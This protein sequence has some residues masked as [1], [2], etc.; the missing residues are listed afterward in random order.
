[1]IR[2]LAPALVLLLTSFQ[3]TAQEAITREHWYEAGTTNFDVHSLL[4]REKTGVMAT[5]L[6][7]WRQIAVSVLGESFSTPVDPIRTH[8]FLF[9]SRG[10]YDLFAEGEDDAYMY[11]SPRASYLILMDDETSVNLAQHHYAHFLINNRPVGSPRWY[12]EGMANYFSRIDVTKEEA[13][14]R[15]LQTT[16]V[17]LA[18]TLNDSLS[19]EEL[20][21]DDAALASPRLIQIANLKSA[22]FVHFLLNG[23]QFEGFT[24]RR[25]QLQNYLGFLQ[26]GRAQRFAY[27]RAF[28]ISL[29]RLEREYERF[30]QMMLD[31]GDP[32]RLLMSFT[33]ELA[34]EASPAVGDTITSELA[35]LSLHAGK[36]ESS[37]LF[38]N[39]LVAK[40][41]QSGRAYSGLADSRRMAFSGEGAEPDV[42]SSYLKAID[43]EPSDPQLFLD[44][45]Q[46]LDTELKSCERQYSV[47]ERQ[48][49][50]TDMRASFEKA[51]ALAP[52]RPEV[53]LSYA[54]IFL[55]DGEQWQEGS[56]YQQRAFDALPADS[57]VMEQTIYYAIAAGR[58]ADARALIVRLARPMHFWGIPGWIA[59]L[60]HKVDAAEQGIAFEPCAA[61][62]Q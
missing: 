16:E 28:D 34:A 35:E 23:D 38:F 29:P 3:I 9:D 21:Y 62:G 39:T 59:D 56:S 15:G 5:E 48:R 12:E 46:Y 19:L 54:Q 33:P 36:Y 22:M 53:N 55:M 2:P 45:G 52:N 32:D 6:E 24:S 13:T 7:A 42:E 17:E 30:I 61:V 26:Q 41:T 25:T 4:S 43:L 31:A 49:M 27:D 57:F 50:A 11:F 1:M 18:I 20:L 8:V 10:N 51:L 60:S 14:Q 40:G 37:E 44:H 47:E 58:Y